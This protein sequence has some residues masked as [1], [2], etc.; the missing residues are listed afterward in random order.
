MEFV[1]IRCE[2]LSVKGS[3]VML[4]VDVECWVVALIGKEGG[5]TS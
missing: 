2:L 5:N 3:N 1:N 4:W